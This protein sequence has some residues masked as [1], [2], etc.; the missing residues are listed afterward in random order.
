MYQDYSCY[1][2]LWQDTC[3]ALLKDISKHRCPSRESHALKS[4]YSV[5]LPRRLCYRRAFYPDMS[6]YTHR[7][8]LPHKTAPPQYR[9]PE[10]VHRCFCRNSYLL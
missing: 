2:D 9:N 10:N 1:G 3:T 5:L 4:R 7:I 8:L 6:E